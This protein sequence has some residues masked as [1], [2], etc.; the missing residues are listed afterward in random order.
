M[1]REAE[2]KDPVAMVMVDTEAQAKRLVKQLKADKANVD[3]TK[4]PFKGS[5]VAGPQYFEGEFD[6]KSFEDNSLANSTMTKILNKV[7]ELPKTD[8]TETLKENI[9]Q[10]YLQT[11][12][13]TSFAQAF[14]ARKGTPGYIIDAKYAFN[15]KAYDIARQS[16]R[17]EYAR[18]LRN[19]ETDIGN[20]KYSADRDVTQS[21]FGLFKQRLIRDA[22][23]GYNPPSG[24]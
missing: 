1:Q 5:G 8:E 15:R 10:L 9:M 21:K 23:G 7:D 16:T 4:N 22:R 11:L 18:K 3:S 17:I 20:L 2:G 19:I 13:E 6:S 12:P 24:F 14:Q